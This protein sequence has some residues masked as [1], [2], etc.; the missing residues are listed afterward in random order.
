MEKFIALVKEQE[1]VSAIAN[2]QKHIHL[3]D[4][5]ST[6]TG[7]TGQRS[8]NKE[9]AIAQA[10]SA[11]AGLTTAVQTQEVQG[12]CGDVRK[13]HCLYVEEQKQR[14]CDSAMATSTAAGLTTAVQTQEVQGRCGDVRKTPLYVQRKNIGDAIAQW[15][16]S[17]P[18]DRPQHCK[19]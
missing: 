6:N 18:L 10:T 2:G 3:I 19:C 7:G 12:R 1:M 8:K 13:T 5:S 11:A 15:P 17:Q 9:G 14:R 4:R 16:P